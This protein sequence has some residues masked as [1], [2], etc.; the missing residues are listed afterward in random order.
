MSQAL[1]NFLGWN[2]G[3]LTN[4]KN[5]WSKQCPHTFKEKENLTAS[6]SCINVRKI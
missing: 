6:D 2:I 1:N 4:I 5:C 3:I